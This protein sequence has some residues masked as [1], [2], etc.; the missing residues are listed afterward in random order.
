MIYDK[1]SLVKKDSKHFIGYKDNKKVIWLHV[2]LPKMI[3]YTNY[4]LKLS[5]VCNFQ[6][7]KIP[8]E[9]DSQ[10][11]NFFLISLVM[12]RGKTK[13]LANE[14]CLL[15]AKSY[16]TALKCLIDAG[17]GINGGLEFAELFNKRGGWN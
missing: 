3:G 5:T 15:F 1:V 10:F 11:W 17:I 2:T 7:M 6:S 16:R 9:L 13:R 8:M 4:L 14:T 12:I